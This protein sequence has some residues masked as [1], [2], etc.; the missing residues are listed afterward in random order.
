M[1][2]FLQEDDSPFSYSSYQINV[3]K[4]CKSEVCETRHFGI[5]QPSKMAKSLELWEHFLE[6]HLHFKSILIILAA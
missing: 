5:F 2:K 4:L 1:K 3:K 6:P